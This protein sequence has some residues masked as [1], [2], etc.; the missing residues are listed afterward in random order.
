MRYRGVTQTQLVLT[1][2][3]ATSTVATTGA[4]VVGCVCAAQ[5]NEATKGKITYNIFIS[6]LRLKL[7]IIK[8]RLLRLVQLII[9]NRLTDQ[10]SP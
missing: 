9:T 3:V 4:A 8:S 7:I 1:T 6:K 10:S 2:G 5:P